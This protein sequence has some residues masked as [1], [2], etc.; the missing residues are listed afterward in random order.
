MK[1]IAFTNSFFKDFTG[2][3]LAVLDAAKYFIK[4]GYRVYIFTFDS[5]K[6]LLS[7][8]SSEITVIN[9]LKDKIPNLKVDILWGQHWA[10]MTKLLENQN[11]YAE[12]IIH[13]SLS[14]YHEYEREPKYATSLS[15]CFANAYETAFVRENENP[16]LKINIFNN[17]VLPEF[18]NISAKPNS[19]LKKLAIVS[20]NGVFLPGNKFEK[21]ITKNN[22]EI[23]FFGTNANKKII[24]P[25]DLIGFD[26]VLTIGRTVQYAMAL[27]IPVF[28]YDR[29]G[30]PGYIN[31]S[32]WQQCEK[33]NYSGRTVI[34]RNEDVEQ[35]LINNHD[36]KKIVNDLINNY[37]KTLNDLSQLQEIARDRYNLFK[38]IE[39]ALENLPNSNLTMDDINLEK[40][41]ANKI[42]KDF[43]MPQPKKPILFKI[44]RETKRIINQIKDLFFK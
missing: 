30:G 20:N 4:N 43:F 5:G 2:S 12:K 39:V 24:T 40:E 37:S 35:Q 27:G 7:E 44:K 26:A 13:F 14:P 31:L 1:T 34:C 29:F 28:C 17:S 32:N 9:I 16:N 38:N 33:M 11:F 3:E 6:P 10:V 21:L 23:K 42:I 18:F 41:N 36:I 25:N 15:K 22:I 8:I 19:I